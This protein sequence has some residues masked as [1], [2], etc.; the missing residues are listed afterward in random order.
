MLFY[1]NLRGKKTPEKKNIKVDE[2][3]ELIKECTKC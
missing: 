2:E 1:Y 3:E